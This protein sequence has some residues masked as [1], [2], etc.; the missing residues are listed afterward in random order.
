MIEARLVGATNFRDE[1]SSMSN[2]NPMAPCEI[3][4]RWEGLRICW[5]LSAQEEGALLGQA[6]LIGP[7]ED[8]CSWQAS[9]LEQQMRLLTEVADSLDTLLVNED[10]IRT[11]LRVPQGALGNLSPLE[12]MASSSQWAEFIR[13]SALM[14][15]I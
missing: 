12:A 3:L 1:G 8:I 10:R 5:A 9:S 2:Y 4:S 15:V 14:F 11:W 13:R 7:V 6:I